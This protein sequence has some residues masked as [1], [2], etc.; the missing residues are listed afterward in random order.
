MSTI[1]TPH[2][3]QESV[4]HS[5]YAIEHGIEN[6]VPKELQPAVKRQCEFLEEVRSLLCG[7]F[8]EDVKIIP[9]SF[10]RGPELN[11]AIGGVDTS[12]HMRGSATDFHTSVGTL[13]EVFEVIEE[14]DLQFDQLIEEHDKEGHRWIHISTPDEGNKARREVLK[15]E[16]G[17][18]LQR[19][20][21]G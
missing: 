7:H 21:L 14:S 4:E 5:D 19:I 12:Q 11:R 10:F 13:D 15:G 20:A 18:R 2:F 3:T 16:K 1:I 9:S 6:H 8:G 17:Q